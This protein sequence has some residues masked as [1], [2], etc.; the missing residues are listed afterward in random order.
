MKQIKKSRKEPC[1]SNVDPFYCLKLFIEV[2]LLIATILTAISAYQQVR[3]ANENIQ[4]TI[5]LNF[6]YI[7]VSQL[8]SPR[9]ITSSLLMDKND[10]GILIQFQIINI[11]D[12][13]SGPIL[14]R[15]TNIP[16]TFFDLKD[17]DIENLDAHSRVVVNTTLHHSYCNANNEV[18]PDKCNSSNLDKGVYI[19]PINI[20]CDACKDSSTITG[21][22]V[23]K[24]NI[25]E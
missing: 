14:I 8:N 9:V 1:C 4:E 19:I 13:P 11:G 21:D 22:T 7:Y 10:E 18:T 12:S 25:M 16:N 24:I 2:G 17:I 23:I 20:T 5:N 3:S 15:Q 6:P